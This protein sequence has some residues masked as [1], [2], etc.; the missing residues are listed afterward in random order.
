MLISFTVEN[1]R[2][3]KEPQTISMVASTEDDGKVVHATGFNSAKHVVSTTAIFGANGSGK[4]NLLKALDFFQDFVRDSSKDRNVDDEIEVTPFLFCPECKAKPSSFEIVF[5]TNGMLFEYG[6]AADKYKVH[7]EWLYATPKDSEKQR[8]QKWFERN[9]A[10]PFGAMLKGQKAAWLEA[11]RDN[12]LLLSTAVQQNSEMLKP[13]FNWIAKQLKIMLKP[14]RL[15]HGFTVKQSEN[16]KKEEIS[17]ILRSLDLS[18]ND[19]EIE[20]EEINMNSLDIPKNAPEFVREFVELAKKHS[21][22]KPHIKSIVFS[23]HKTIGDGFHM[24]PL[25]AESDGTKKLFCFIG[26]LLDILENGYVLIADELNNSLHPH[27]MQ[28]IIEMFQNP[29]I[30]TKGAQLLFTTHE[31]KAMDYMNDDRIWL[32]ERGDHGETKAVALSQFGE[33]SDAALEKRYLSGRYGAIPNI[34]IEGQ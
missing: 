13:I 12:A 10:K 2:S 15:H 9:D 24:L 25:D 4:S 20:K 23:K 11:T 34:Q 19:F 17:K 8:R 30:N 6:F 1:Y 29:Q 7:D 18:F 32:L 27:A 26:H 14:E 31:T 3:I 16:G 5:I 21:T 33:R 22:E 28:A